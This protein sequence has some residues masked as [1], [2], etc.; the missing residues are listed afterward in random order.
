ML[1]VAFAGMDVKRAMVA[2]RRQAHPGGHPEGHLPLPLLL[3]LLRPAQL[4]LA[5]D[6]PLLRVLP[7]QPLV[8]P[9]PVSMLARKQVAVA[10]EEEAAAAVEEETGEMAVVAAEADSAAIAEFRLQDPRARQEQLALLVPT[11]SL[12][13]QATPARM[14]C[15][16][17][18]LR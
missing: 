1:A 15:H 9:V 8:M 17:P 6:R 5:P 13:R 2:V 3:P 18:L 10:A 12:G 14:H 16:P 7:L 11:D 4:Q